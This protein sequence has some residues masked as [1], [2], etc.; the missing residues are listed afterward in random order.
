VLVIFTL[1]GVVK[2]FM[3]KGVPDT[4]FA[5]TMLKSGLIEFNAFIHTF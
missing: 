3:R 1:Y 2:G 5:N 4:G